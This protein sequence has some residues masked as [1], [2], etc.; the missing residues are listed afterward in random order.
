MTSRQRRPKLLKQ[1][2]YVIRRKGYSIRRVLDAV[3]E[4]GD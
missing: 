2:R 1:V 4:I 3:L